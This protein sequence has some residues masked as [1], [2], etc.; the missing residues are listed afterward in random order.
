MAILALKKDFLRTELKESGH[1]F[2]DGSEIDAL[3]LKGVG[4]LPCLLRG[5]HH[6]KDKTAASKDAFIALPM[7]G[8]FCGAPAFVAAFETASGEII[9]P[10]FCNARLH[11]CPVKGASPVGLIAKLLENVRTV[12]PM[13]LTSPHYDGVAGIREGIEVSNY[14]CPERIEMNVPDQSE[15][16]WFF[17]TKD[18]FVPV[19][20]KM[21]GSL[22]TLVE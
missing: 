8:V 1:V 6:L 19:L 18:G 17:L 9:P 2:T 5:P 21:T 7:A 15:Q 11:E 20:E 4:A 10:A 14:V 13:S 16:V 12:L 3:D 22:M